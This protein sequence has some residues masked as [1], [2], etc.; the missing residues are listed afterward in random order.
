LWIISVVLLLSGEVYAFGSNACGQLGVGDLAPRGGPVLIQV[1]GI[2]IQVA[3]GSNHTVLLTT[4]GEIYTV[5][6][7]QVS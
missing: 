5:G 1:P 6:S 4:E 7:F 3:A 2:V